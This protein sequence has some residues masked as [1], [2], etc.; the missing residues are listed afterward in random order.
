MSEEEQ[1]RKAI[2][3]YDHFLLE[4][5]AFRLPEAES[6]SRSEEPFVLLQAAAG[7]FRVVVPV[8]PDSPHY[9]R[10]IIVFAVFPRLI[11]FWM[12]SDNLIYFN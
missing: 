9:Y 5:R 8:L 1:I 2:G 10:L 11:T 12:R 3:N 6:F 7:L 4:L